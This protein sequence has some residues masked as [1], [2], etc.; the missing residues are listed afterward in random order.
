[1]T[2]EGFHRAAIVAT[3]FPFLGPDVCVVDIW[4]EG[5][6]SDTDVCVSSSDDMDLIILVSSPSDVVGPFPV[7]A[8]V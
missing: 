6:L 5:Y 7:I 4:V 2:G 3:V 8:N 1:M